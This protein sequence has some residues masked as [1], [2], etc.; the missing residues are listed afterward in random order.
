MA[1]LKLSHG[2]LPL[3]QSLTTLSEA[4][5]MVATELLR[6]QCE[7]PCRPYETALRSARSAPLRRRMGSSLSQVQFWLDR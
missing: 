1:G 4:V 5:G 3:A 2:S 7:R 6:P